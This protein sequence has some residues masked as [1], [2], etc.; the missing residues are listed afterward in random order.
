M[1]A[2]TALSAL[3]GEGM[4]EMLGGRGDIKRKND[5][6]YSLGFLPHGKRYTL[7]SFVVAP[8]LI[9]E[10][11]FGMCC[12]AL[13]GFVIENFEITAIGSQAKYT[14]RARRCHEQP[15]Y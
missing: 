15:S 1:D 13:P 4:V 12:G 6:R 9:G 5:F 11:K 8:K 7:D 3:D 2:Y 14:G 10:G